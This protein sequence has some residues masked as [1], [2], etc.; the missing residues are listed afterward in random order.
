MKY[1]IRTLWIFWAAVAVLTI[2]KGAIAS[3][4]NLAVRFRLPTPVEKTVD[5]VKYQ[6]LTTEQWGEVILVAGQNKSLF[7]SRLETKSALEGYAWMESK[8]ELMITN[9]EAQV[10]TLQADRTHLTKRIT[11]EHQ[12]GLDLQRNKKLGVITWQIISGVELAAIVVVVI[13]YAMA[14]NKGQTIEV[15]P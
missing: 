8:Y 14:G 2:V 7:N 13:L 5:G 3:D 9:F 1:F 6:C 4:D 15:H 11:Q 10:T 12:W